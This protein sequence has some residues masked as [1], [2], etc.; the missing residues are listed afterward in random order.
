MIS[1]LQYFRQSDNLHSISHASYFLIGYAAGLCCGSSPD[2]LVSDRI[3]QINLCFRDAE[4][5]EEAIKQLPA[6]NQSAESFLRALKQTLQSCHS[7]VTTLFLAACPDKAVNIRSDKE[8]HVL[9]ETL[10]RSTFSEAYQLYNVK[11]CKLRDI[12]AALREYKPSILHFSGHASRNGLVFENELGGFNVIDT[13]SL[14]LVMER[15]V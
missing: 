9:E 8:H 10:Q 3:C 5:R 4:V 14:A 12:T 2:D 15:G 7:R 13:A 1:R 11:S 6:R